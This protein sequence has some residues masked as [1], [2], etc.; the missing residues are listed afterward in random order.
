MKKLIAI[1][2]ATGIGKT[3]MAI[4]LANHFKTEIIL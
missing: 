2:G 1:S 4:R 3:E